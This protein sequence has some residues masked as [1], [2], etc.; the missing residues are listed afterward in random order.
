MATRV[1]VTIEDCVQD[2]ESAMVNAAERVI[3]QSVITFEEFVAERITPVAPSTVHDFQRD[4]LS[5]MLT[6][7]SSQCI[8]HMEPRLHYLWRLQ[9]ELIRFV[10]RFPWTS[11]DFFFPVFVP[12][13]P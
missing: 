2:E 13:A 1:I 10:A 6:Q 11:S 4:W 7:I 5:Y 8:V 3:R 12:Q 9:S